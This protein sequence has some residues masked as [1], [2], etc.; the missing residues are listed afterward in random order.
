MDLRWQ[1]LRLS[2]MVQCWTADWKYNEESAHSLVEAKGKY[3]DDQSGGE[4]SEGIK[5]WADHSLGEGVC[6]QQ[7]WKIFQSVLHSNSHQ[8]LK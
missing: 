7:E 6:T 4:R 1:W 3:C 2:E 5:Q 8:K